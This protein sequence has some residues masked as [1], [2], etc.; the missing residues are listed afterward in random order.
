MNG[1]QFGAREQL[2]KMYLMNELLHKYN[3]NGCEVCPQM[4]NTNSTN[5][6]EKRRKKMKKK[7]KQSS[8]ENTLWIKEKTVWEDLYHQLSMWINDERQKYALQ[9]NDRFHGLWPHQ[10]LSISWGM[11]KIT[12]QDI[13]WINRVECES[14]YIMHISDMNNEKGFTKGIKFWNVFSLSLSPFLVLSLLF[15]I[16]YRQICWSKLKI[17]ENFS[18]CKGIFENSFFAPIN[19]YLTLLKLWNRKCYDN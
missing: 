17:N 9:R 3:A 18:F 2:K 14:W 16:F 5:N 11:K 13:E 15:Y 10:M 19:A 12:V 1:M 7:G 6:V 4:K 8:V